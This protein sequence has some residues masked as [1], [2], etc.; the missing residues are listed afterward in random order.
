M[1]FDRSYYITNSISAF[2]IQPYIYERNYFHNIYI[3]Y[4]TLIIVK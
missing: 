4:C 3:K 2:I 1:M